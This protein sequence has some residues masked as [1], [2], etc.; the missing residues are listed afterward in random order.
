M[1][2]VKEILPNGDLVVSGRGLFR[3]TAG[4]KVKDEL[5]NRMEADAFLSG[6]NAFKGGHQAV[7]TRYVTLAKRK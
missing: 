1:F 6:Y 2:K 4:G 3:I 7:A 5:L